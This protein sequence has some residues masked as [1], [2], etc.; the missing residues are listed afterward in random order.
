MQFSEQWLRTWLN[1]S[2][3]TEELGDTLTMGDLEVD[4]FAPAAPAF[5]GIVVGQIL[6]MEKH[7]DADKLNVS[8]VDACTGEFLHVI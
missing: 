4:R 3:T 6:S 1:P 7:P 8:Q 5:T 2:M